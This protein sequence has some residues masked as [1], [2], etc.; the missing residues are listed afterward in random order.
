MAFDEPNWGLREDGMGSVGRLI[1]GPNLI[2][3]PSGPL[4][5]ESS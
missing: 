3:I 5:G 2:I 1:S 4:A